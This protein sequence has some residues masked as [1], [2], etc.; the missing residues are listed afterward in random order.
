MKRE[1]NFMLLLGILG[2]ANIG[3]NIFTN[4]NI[5]EENY[6][7]EII[8]TEIHGT[9]SGLK[10]TLNFDPAHAEQDALCA[11]IDTHSLSTVFFLKTRHAFS[12]EAL[13]VEKYPTIVFQS[14]AI[15]KNGNL[16]E[17]TGKLTVKDVTKRIIIS[18]T[19][20]GTDVSRAFK[21]SFKI[22]PKEY[23]LTCNGTPE[24]VPLALHILEPVLNSYTFSNDLAEL[25]T[26]NESLNNTDRGRDLSGIQRKCTD[27]EITILNRR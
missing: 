27:Q 16:Y 25:A 3:F 20:N 23:H 21:G 6:S 15:T 13:D 11:S 1:I 7:I 14:D 17:A 2:L 24:K 4:W 22:S 8:G 26:M 18:F 5:K 19:F 10:A 9:F 12:K